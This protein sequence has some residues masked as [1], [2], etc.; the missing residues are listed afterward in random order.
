[1]RYSNIVRM[2]RRALALSSIFI[3]MF[4]IAKSLAGA[5][6]QIQPASLSPTFTGINPQPTSKGEEKSGMPSVQAAEDKG[7]GNSAKAS[8]EDPAD[9]TAQLKYSA[10]VKWMAH[11]LGVSM[12]TAYELSVTLNFVTIVAV[13][14]LFL[15]SKLPGWFRSRTQLIRQGLDEARDASAEAQQRL[16]AIESRIAKLQSEIAGMQT[17]AEQE[18]EAEEQRIRANAETDKRKIVEAAEQ[19]IAAAANQARRDF[20]SYTAD[21][22]V[23]LAA[24]RIEVDAATDEGLLFAF[25][26]QLGHNGSN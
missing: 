3:V 9:K 26:D 17:A 8:S 24:K 16:T 20:K 7:I 21:L 13:A 14:V 25:I 10:S 22:A 19:E 6:A 23:T 2:F 4:L 15:R 5:K 11:K 18:S 12:F 1:M